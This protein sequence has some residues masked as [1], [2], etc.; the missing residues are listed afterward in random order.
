MKKVIIILVVLVGLFVGGLFLAPT[1]L[2]NDLIESTIKKQAGLDVKIKGDVSISLFPNVVFSAD[3]LQIKA[4]NGNKP[5][6][7][8]GPVSADVDLGRLL[9]GHLYI[10]DFSWTKPQV[11]LEVSKKGVANWLPKR[12]SR[13]SKKADLSFLKGVDKSAIK[14]ISVT[15]N[16]IESGQKH[17]LERGSL[18]VTSKQGRKTDLAFSAKMAGVPIKIISGFDIGN[19]AG[20]PLNMKLTVNKNNDVFIKGRMLDAFTAPSFNGSLNVDGETFVASLKKMFKMEKAEIEEV[21]LKLSATISY[22]KIEASLNDFKIDLGKMSLG[23]AIHYLQKD[24]RP[25]VEIRLKGSSLDLDALGICGTKA[26]VNNRRNT[27]HQWPDG[28]IDL[29]GLKNIDSSLHLSWDE[30]KCDRFAFEPVV[31]RMRVNHEGILIDEVKLSQSSGGYITT[32]GKIED[33]E[34]ILGKF[35]VRWSDLALEQV[36][37]ESAARFIEM[38]LSGTSDISFSGKSIK[39]WVNSTDGHIRFV[40]K[41][42]TIKGM[43]LNNLLAATMDVIMGTQPSAGHNYK[44]KSLTGE[45]DISEG[46][47]QSK[48]VE[49]DVADILIKGSGKISLPDWTISYALDA[50]NRGQLI[51][52]VRIKGSLTEP[53]VTADVAKRAIGAGIGTAV[54]GPLG[55]VIG[56]VIG[57]MLDK[58]GNPVEPKKEPV[59]PF[60]LRDKDNLEDNVRKFL[61][62]GFSEKE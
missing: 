28:I 52:T 53:Q 59:L 58:D 40:T 37:A 61:R 49:L 13:H 20:V 39:Q 55:G 42:G 34:T 10:N 1:F 56:G 62:D 21:P 38:P 3:G 8:S 60:D 12:K 48:K 51:P 44:I 25:F 16:N 7:T 9:S 54:G 19:P 24:S 31:V 43:D 11:Y 46:V 14:N 29:T 2:S 18:L 27:E 4:H 41:K 26:V 47:I 35:Q 45:F 5:L 50:K 30:V 32:K 36:V 23:G 6:L 22:E 57:G 33:G 17:I 15:Y